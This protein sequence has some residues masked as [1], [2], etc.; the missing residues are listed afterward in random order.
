M[1]RD[2]GGGG[3][4]GG[5]GE[6]GLPTHPF[7]KQRNIFFKSHVQSPISPQNPWRATCLKN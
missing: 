2:F 3:G 7:I 1:T 5:N 6:E 4:G